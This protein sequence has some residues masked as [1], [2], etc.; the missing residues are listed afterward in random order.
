VEIVIALLVAS[1][2]LAIAYLV[3]RR[4]TWVSRFREAT[5]VHKEYWRQRRTEA[6]E[7]L[8]VA[9]GDSAA[10]GIGA[11]IPDNGYV[12]ILARRIRERTGGSLRVVNL[13]IVGGTVRTAIDSQ[14]PT[15]RKLQPDIVTVS[16][17]ANNILAF[18]EAVFERDLREL[19]AAMPDHAIIAELPSFHF[20]PGERNVRLANTILRAMA[21]E[22][23]MPV[24]PLH[25]ATARPIAVIRHFAGDLFHPNDR[26][27]RAWAAA[28]EAAIDARLSTLSVPR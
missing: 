23:G 3:H 9:V 16:V 7:L 22:R 27:Y 13:G 17:G 15:F 20:L 14:L 2:V 25:A 12:G 18:D 24:A 28:F 10:Q 21:A 5:P 1:I 19:L 26:G 8:Y 4:R 6:G 11:S